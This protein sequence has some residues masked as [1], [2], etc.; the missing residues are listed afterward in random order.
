[1]AKNYIKKKSLSYYI[2]LT[3]EKA[4]DGYV[5]IEDYTYHSYKYMYGIPDLKKSELSQALKR[6]RERGLIE[7]DKID[8][9]KVVLKLTELGRDVLGAEFDESKWDGKW[10]V[11]IFDIPEQKRVVRDMFRRKLKHWGFKNWQKSVWITKNN[12]TEK[13][14]KTVKELGIEK[15]VAIVES[16]NISSDNNLFNDR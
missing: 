10:R 2:L 14:R 4:I 16:D 8:T 13:L 3:L 7:E 11:V 6:L 5:R 1:M 15:W 12:V 9:D